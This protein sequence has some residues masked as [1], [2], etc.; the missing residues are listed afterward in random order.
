MSLTH[1]CIVKSG[2]SKGVTCAMLCHAAGDSS[3]GNL[4]PDTRVVALESKDIGDIAK[5]L[6]DRSIPHHLVEE[7]GELL[8]IGLEPALELDQ[9]KR[10]T[11]SLPLIR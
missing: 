8:A 7:D 11:S 2:L 10:V 5:R 4:P 1:Y 9:I 3:P 6:E